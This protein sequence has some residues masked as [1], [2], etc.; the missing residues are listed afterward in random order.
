MKHTYIWINDI[1]NNKISEYEYR[2]P[3]SRHK[4]VCKYDV[5]KLGSWLWIIVYVLNCMYMYL[6]LIVYVLEQTY[7]S[8]TAGERAIVVG[9]RQCYW[10]IVLMTYLVFGYVALSCLWLTGP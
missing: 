7:V 1:Y 6:K 9:V 4:N 2:M 10:S 8:Q 3:N 5:C